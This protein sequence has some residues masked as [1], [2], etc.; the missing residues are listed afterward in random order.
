MWPPHI[1]IHVHQKQPLSTSSPI[2][3]VQRYYRPIQSN[4]LWKWMGILICHP[5][6]LWYKHPHMN[7][8]ITEFYQNHPTSFGITALKASPTNHVIT[9]TLTLNPVQSPSTPLL[10]A[11]L[12]IK[13]LQFCLPNWQQIC[14]AFSKLLPACTSKG[15]SVLKKL[16]RG[17]VVPS[18][19]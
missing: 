7:I 1:A 9:S 10:R 2:Y 19:F 5:K 4:F 14:F 15:H 12:P 3:L 17:Y 16:K 8:E 13:A 18:L 6:T 11:T